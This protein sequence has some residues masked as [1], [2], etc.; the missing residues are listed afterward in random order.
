MR[1]DQER[2]EFIKNPNN[3]EVL[4]LAGI[5][6]LT[7]LIRISCLQY[8]GHEWYKVEVYQTTDMYDVRQHKTVDATGWRLLHY[9]KL[10][11]DT[12]AFSYGI[13]ITQIVNEI[14]EIDRERRKT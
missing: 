11:E 7:D 10:N 4:T 5:D 1:N 8:R 12:K 2:Q 13:S 9:Y 14:K 6:V 3:W